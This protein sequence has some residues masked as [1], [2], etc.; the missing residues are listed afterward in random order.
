MILDNI[1]RCVGKHISKHP[2]IYIHDLFQCPEPLLD[3]CFEGITAVLLATILSPGFA[4]HIHF[5]SLLFLLLAII[6]RSLFVPK[7]PLQPLIDN[8]R[9]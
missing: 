7:P 1:P 6:P 2:A 4:T 5:L 3:N 9:I 8:E